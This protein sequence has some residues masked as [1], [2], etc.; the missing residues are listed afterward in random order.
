MRDPGRRWQRPAGTPG[1]GSPGSGPAPP[2][3]GAGRRR[4][5]GAS[6]PI[7]GRWQGGERLEGGLPS[8]GP[9]PYPGIPVHRPVLL[10]GREE[11]DPVVVEK[12]RIFRRRGPLVGEGRNLIL[13]PAGDVVF[14]RHALAHLPQALPQNML[15][16]DGPDGLQVADA[17]LAQHRHLRRNGAGPLELPQPLGGVAGIAHRQSGDRFRSP[18]QRPSSLPREDALRPQDQGL[19]GRGAGETDTE[20]GNGRRQGG[21]QHG[22]PPQ[23]GSV[24]HG[25]D[26]PEDAGADLLRWN[27]GTRHHLRRHHSG[28]IDDI[29]FLQA[30]PRRHEGSAA[31]AH[32]RHPSAH[33]L[34]GPRGPPGLRKGGRRRGAGA[35]HGVRPCRHLLGHGGLV[36]RR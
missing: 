36:G 5:Q 21:P 33:A 29:Q 11:G 13:G 3:A 32:H 7:E 23:I 30:P 25:D 22:L 18:H 4:R 6:L 15:F 9:A 17:Q 19:A 2:K 8:S 10:P 26:H 24:Q 20:T 34:E 12:A 14:P 35:A 1:D 16:D 28:Q 27:G 31:P